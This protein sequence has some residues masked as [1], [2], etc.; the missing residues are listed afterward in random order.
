LQ[1]ATDFESLPRYTWEHKGW[2]ISFTA[3][4]RSPERRGS[5]QL[6]VIG[7]LM[8]EAQWISPWQSISSAIKAKG[9]RCGKLDKA[10]V[11]AVNA[12]NLHAERI[13]EMEALFGQEDYVFSR[14]DLNEAPRIVR[15][16]N[17]VWYGP[18]G[19]RNKRISAVLIARNLQPWTMATCNVILYLNPFA[20][21]P[22]SGS[23]CNLDRAVPQEDGRMTFV[24]G[25]HPREYLGL[26]ENW[27]GS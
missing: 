19:T 2:K 16:R 26:P 7:S 10:F 15:K 27:P 24:T 17:G 25:I 23:I 4:P 18:Q 21:Y 14:A 8:P 6:R 12:T 22:L 1:Q 20:D 9:K 5:P 3:V 13:D 11:V